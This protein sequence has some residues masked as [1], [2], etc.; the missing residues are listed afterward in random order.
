VN[1]NE[2]EIIIRQKFV[3]AAQ[4]IWYYMLGKPIELLAKIW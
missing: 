4:E 2:N 3:E 1:Y